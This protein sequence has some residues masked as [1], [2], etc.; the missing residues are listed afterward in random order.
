MAQTNVERAA[1]LRAIAASFRANAAQTE[2]P[3]YRTRMLD[4]ASELEREAV[5]ID[6]FLLF[7]LAS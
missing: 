6:P 2:W 5:R 1:R 4:M 3:A 7:F